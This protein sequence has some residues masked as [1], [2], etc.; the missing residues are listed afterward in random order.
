MRC[1][2]GRKKHTEILSRSIREKKYTVYILSRSV[3]E[4]KYTVYILSR[5]VR[6]KKYT[7]Y[8]LFRTVRKKKDMRKCSLNSDKGFQPL[9]AAAAAVVV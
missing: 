5:T 9:A 6:E 3:Q 7:V 8:I 4:K 1:P 2:Y